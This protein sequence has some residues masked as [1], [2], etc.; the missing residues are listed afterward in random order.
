V[1]SE[2]S[3]GVV[4]DLTERTMEEQVYNCLQGLPCIAVV[5]RPGAGAQG[6]GETVAM[7]L[8]TWSGVVP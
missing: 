4:V 5:N 1:E 7:S 3:G 8:E 6:A 2:E